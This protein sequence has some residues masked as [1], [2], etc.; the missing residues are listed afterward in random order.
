MLPKPRNTTFCPCSGQK[1]PYGLSQSTKQ[2]EK[3]IF[4]WESHPIMVLSPK[5]KK[6]WAQPNCGKFHTKPPTVGRA[7][8]G[9]LARWVNQPLRHLWRPASGFTEWTTT[10][11]QYRTHCTFS[12]W[13]RSYWWQ[14]ISP[15]NS[16]GHKI[17]SFMCF[18]SVLKTF[19]MW[20]ILIF[21]ALQFKDA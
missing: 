16:A 20:R 7:G 9:H 18:R 3:N 6:Y 11:W 1:R 4:L 2:K 13:F 14:S 8:Q 15:W 5:T 12:W 21:T 19:C 10:T 17:K